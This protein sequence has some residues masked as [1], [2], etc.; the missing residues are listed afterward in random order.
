MVKSVNE[1]LPPC[2]GLGFIYLKL[3]PHWHASQDWSPKSSCP[4]KIRGESQ[5]L[6]T[7]IWKLVGHSVLTF[8]EAVL[9]QALLN[10]DKVMKFSHICWIIV[11]I[12]CTQLIYL[13]WSVLAQD[14]NKNHH[15]TQ[16]HIFILW[17]SPQTI[18]AVWGVFELWAEGPFVFWSVLIPL[19]ISHIS[20]IVLCIV[21]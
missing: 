14:L 2:T 17:N 18:S 4:W 13:L 6:R 15:Q 20:S 8:E 16:C 12:S 11:K 3:I 10:S 5:Y 9:S 1:T 21:A 19:R 7:K